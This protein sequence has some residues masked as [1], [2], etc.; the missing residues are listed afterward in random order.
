MLELE[1]NLN[2]AADVAETSFGTPV[3]DDLETDMETLQLLVQFLPKDANIYD[4][5]YCRGKVIEHWQQLGFICYNK[6]ED[7]YAVDKPPDG[8]TII[9]TK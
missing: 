2:T 1:T 7:F 5:Y 3:T 9:I 8:V 4:P 6:P